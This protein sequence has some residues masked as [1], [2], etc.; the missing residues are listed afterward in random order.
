[1]R[2][3]DEVFGTHTKGSWFNNLNIIGHTGD[4]HP[5]YFGQQ[6]LAESLEASIKSDGVVATHSKSVLL[7]GDND[8]RDGDVTGFSNIA[9]ALEARGFQV[10]EDNSVTLPSDYRTYGQIWFYGYYPPNPTDYASLEAYVKDGGGLFLSGEWG[11]VDMFANAG[12]QAVVQA[13]VSLSISVSGDAFNAVVPV[14]TNAIDHVATSPNNL[15]TWTPSQE[16]SL[17]N[18]A[19]GNVLFAGT[20]GDGAVWNA[21]GGRLAV[22]MDIN[23]AQTNY[24]DPA[25]MPQV[26][27]NIATFL[28]G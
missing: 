4:A 27:Q 23:W 10:T 26:V 1:M 17:A 19:P 13:T 21:G 12:V 2:P 16:G 7:Y 11:P 18:V 14:N 24:E 9:A 25:T 6:A 28:A 15:T 3:T 20:D 8:S 22:L 5:N